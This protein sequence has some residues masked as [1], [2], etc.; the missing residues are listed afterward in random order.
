[1]SGVLKTLIPPKVR[2]WLLIG[3]AVVALL[4]GLMG[5]LFGESSVAPAVLIGL[6]A[7][8]ALALLWGLIW[9]AVRAAKRRRQGQFDASIA[10]REGIDDRKR[11]WQSWV[12]ELNKNKIDRYELPFYLLLGEPQ[13][14]KSVL[15]Q[16]SD[17]KFLFGQSR[18]SGIGGTR[19]CDWWFTDEAV[20]LDLAGRLFTHEGGAADEAEWEAFLDLLTSF[21][22]VDPANG[23][24][25]VIPC[26]SL[27]DDSLE[28]CGH[29]AGKIREALLT[30]T[31]KLQAK[32]PIYTVLTKGDKV[33]GFAE[34]VH[35]L[36]LEER[37]QMFGWSRPADQLD[38]PFEEAELRDAW[39]EFVQRATGLRDRMLSDARIP[40]AQGEVDRMLGFPTEL[41]GLYEPLEVYLRRIFLDS[42]L[43]EQL[44]FR[45]VYLT[46]G[47]Q[48]GAPIAK[49]CLDILDRP[50]EADNRDLETLFVRQQAY[51]IKDLVRKRVFSERG[52]VKPTSTRVQRTQKV[53]WVGYGLAA[54]IALVA[55][56]WGGIQVKTRWDPAR[57]EI[58]GDAITSSRK[59]TP[60]PFQ[61]GVQTAEDGSYPSLGVLASS[62]ERIEEA[63]K[64][65][66]PAWEIAF[67]DR[68]ESLVRLYAAIF[69]VR[70]HRRLR[71]LGSQELTKQ[72]EGYA[73]ESEK[74][75]NP[76]VRPKDFGEFL[77]QA[78]AVAALLDGVPDK[79][80]ASRV[81]KLADPIFEK[82]RLEK[83][84]DARG[85]FQPDPDFMKPEAV[86]AARRLNVLW[87]AVMRPGDP[88]RIGGV[89]G[90]DSVG[91]SLSRWG[92][93]D[94]V[95]KGV[96]DLHG[97]LIS[98][99][100]TPDLSGVHDLCSRARA[101]FHDLREYHDLG[102][103][104]RVEKQE[105]VEF[106]RSDGELTRL[107]DRLQRAAGESGSSW[108]SKENFVEWLVGEGLAAEVLQQQLDGGEAE[109]SI[110][111]GTYSSVNALLQDDRLTRALSTEW[112][113]PDGPETARDF[114]ARIEEALSIEEENDGTARPLLKQ[115]VR[116]KRTSAAGGFVDRYDAWPSLEAEYEAAHADPLDRAVAVQRFLLG[117]HETVLAAEDRHFELLTEH[118]GKLLAEGTQALRGSLSDEASPST[119]AV[120]VLLSTDRTLRSSEAEM[121]AGSPELDA[122]NEHISKLRDD[123]NADWSAA[124]E[125][126]SRDESDS[127]EPPSPAASLVAREAMAHLRG[128]D[129]ALEPATDEQRKR[130]DTKRPGWRRSV[131]KRIETALDDYSARLEEAVRAHAVL[132]VADL[133]GAIQSVRKKLGT[134]NEVLEYRKWRDGLSRALGTPEHDNS[135]LASFFAADSP[136]EVEA[137]DE[138]ADLTFTRFEETSRPGRWA[139]GESPPARLWAYVEKHRKLDE[140]DKDLDGEDLAKRHYE[141][142]LEF[143]SEEDA[144]S[145]RSD[146]IGIDLEFSR[147]LLESFEDAVEAELRR[148]Y[149]RDLGKMAEARQEDVLTLWTE[150]SLLQGGDRTPREDD[151]LA[152]DRLFG[153]EGAYVNHLASYGLLVPDRADFRLRALPGEVEGENWWRLDYF[154]EQMLV[155]VRGGS[156]L[157]SLQLDEGVPELTDIECEI[158]F[159]AL[160]GEKPS[161]WNKFESFSSETFM[162]GQRGYVA[163]RP[164]AEGIVSTEPKVGWSFAKAGTFHLA[165]KLKTQDLETD[166]VP[167]ES[168]SC[169]EPLLLFWSDPKTW[170]SPEHSARTE[171]A[172]VEFEVIRSGDGALT[173]PFRLRLEPAPPRRP[174]SDELPEVLASR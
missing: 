42:D 157:A 61:A 155:Y 114:E 96:E 153:A 135:D 99:G 86:S 49:V 121:T 4:C 132:E 80:A 124:E 66:P 161:P 90:F 117:L 109:R 162:P 65:K 145:G 26:D 71:E 21:R 3:V 85:D 25:L 151:H 87:D 156:D 18:L 163:I 76:P 146:R 53:A 12:E 59:L 10:A 24:M 75:L 33:F 104:F 102:T 123:M 51:F 115:L 67:G 134:T 57:Q 160:E 167:W 113:G 36:S 27:L 52:L 20:I 152:V 83:L 116:I 6:G 84:F 119:V 13:S 122:I 92:L 128:I 2:K 125:A 22:P 50:G 131:V 140:R 94:V 129:Q 137:K 31:R 29:K 127:T 143:L 16:N 95:Q 40:E 69:D 100:K 112:L 82:S 7:L 93:K 136:F 35:R 39:G 142:E 68:R 159:D 43:T 1:M 19:G 41:Q 77:E 28:A 17:L 111:L 118:L 172:T 149:L 168:R 144:L 88:N 5:V 78:R 165:W 171:T 126:E 97:Q 48:S 9:F 173:A 164:V 54:S 15:L 130:I 30:L 105:L 74:P 46:S 133:L 34:S 166:E 158:E 79:V 139:S 170:D 110:G 91:Y 106:Q 14:G 138:E 174:R 89:P 108:K 62:L 32:V 47:L 38:Q 70:F 45:G 154:L 103:S 37:H 150:R 11:E 81:V 44:Y 8:L 73:Y 98:M 101:I 63:R 58:Y 169:L 141:L 55:V 72:V 120:Q 148:D 147:Q 56:V 107:R 60:G 64:L 23:I